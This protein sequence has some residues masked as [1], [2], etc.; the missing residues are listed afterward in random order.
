MPDS[1]ENI[2]T[3]VKGQTCSYSLGE[4]FILFNYVD[5]SFFLSFL[6][7]RHIEVFST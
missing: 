4:Q 1:W 6:N 2:S 7:C 5:F 3:H